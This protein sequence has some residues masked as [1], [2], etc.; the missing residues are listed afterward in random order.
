MF[1]ELEDYVKDEQHNEKQK[2]RK[3]Q[4]TLETYGCTVG[5][6]FNRTRRV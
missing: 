6:I 3:G 5:F 2:W 4:Y 1:Y